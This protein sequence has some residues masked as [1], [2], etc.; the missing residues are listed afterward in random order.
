M[1]CAP[2]QW[3]K[4]MCCLFL[5]SLKNAANKNGIEAGNNL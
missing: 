4:G 3:T 1:E 5:I 2:V